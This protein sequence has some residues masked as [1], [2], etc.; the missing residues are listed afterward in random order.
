MLSPAPRM[1]STQ[2][3]SWIFSH[4][5]VQPL[6]FIEFQQNLELTSLPEAHYMIAVNA[7]ERHQP[8]VPLAI[9]R[10]QVKRFVSTESRDPENPNNFWFGGFFASVISSPP[11]GHG[12][13]WPAVILEQHP[14]YG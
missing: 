5:S 9:P 7:P 1:I 6:L 8:V 13:S 4:R 3:R 12:L 14:P 10:I 2:G 11:R